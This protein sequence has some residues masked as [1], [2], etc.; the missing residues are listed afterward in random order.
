MR[1]A[2]GESDPR[3]QAKKI[4]CLSALVAHLKCVEGNHHAIKHLDCEMERKV[5][6]CAKAAGVEAVICCRCASTFHSQSLTFT[7]NT[8]RQRDT[9]EGA[10]GLHARL[11]IYWNQSTRCEGFQTCLP[12]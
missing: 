5:E 3:V 10:I 12:T 9:Y 6:C 8:A 11:L 1:A 4:H 7:I 2:G